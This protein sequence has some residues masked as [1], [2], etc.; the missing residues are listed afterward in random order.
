MANTAHGS[1]WALEPPEAHWRDHDARQVAYWRSRPAQERLDQA[2]WYR[3]RVFGAL[4]AYPQPRTWRLL[5]P[6]ATE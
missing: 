5:P 4:E 3:V 2:T 6:D 1:R